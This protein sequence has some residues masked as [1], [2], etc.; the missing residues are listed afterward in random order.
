MS[1]LTHLVNFLFP[2]ECHICG[3]P[4]A[5]HER[6]A[7]THCLSTL[8]RSGYHRR[9]LNPM[10]ERFAGMFRFEKATGHF[11]YSRGS[12][13]SELIQDMKYRHFPEIGD[14]LGALAA[15]ELAATGFFYGV[16]VI[17][18]VPMHFW[19]QAKRG[20]NQTHHIAQG[21]GKETGIPV[22][23]ALKAVKGH[24]T[25]TSLTHEQRLAN[26]AGLFK[27][28]LPDEVRGKHVLL[29]D[30]VCTTGSTLTSSADAL[31][32]AKPSELTLFTLGV[33]F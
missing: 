25:Q 12:A 5:P 15:R 22:S 19:K 24:K 10:E 7:C 6:F 33:T 3:A 9:H 8:P 27:V 11:L 32:E 1:V 4:L 30:D 13:L 20:Y 18:P 29:V 26:T 14:M 16:D 17:V 21:I 23:L 2:A 28:A 31:W